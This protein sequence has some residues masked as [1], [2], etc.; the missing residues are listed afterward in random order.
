MKIKTTGSSGKTQLQRYVFL[1]LSDASILFN[2]FMV[3]TEW[4]AYV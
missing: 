1:C 2:I 3:S 4:E